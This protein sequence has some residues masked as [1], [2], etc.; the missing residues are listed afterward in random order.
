MRRR[1]STELSL[2]ASRLDTNFDF[3]WSFLRL[4]CICSAALRAG[5]TEKGGAVKIFEANHRGVGAVSV[6]DCP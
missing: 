3:Y 5:L 4:N 6:Q 2:L 1:Q